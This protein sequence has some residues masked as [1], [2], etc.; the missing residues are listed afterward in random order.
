V[1][2]VTAWPPPARTVVWGHRACI[3]TGGP[4]GGPRGEVPCFVGRDVAQAQWEGAV[5]PAGARGAVPHEA[6]G[7]M[8]LVARVPALHPP[9]IVRE[10][11]GG[12]ERPAPAA[13]APA[14]L[15]GGG[16]NPRPA[17]AVARATGQVAKTA[18]VAARALAHFAAVR[19]PP[20]G[21]CRP[22]SPRS[23]ALAAGAA[24]NA[25]AGARR[26]R[27]AGRGPAAAARR[28]WRRLSPGST[29]GSPRWPRPARRG[30]APARW[31]GPTTTG[32][33]VRRGWAPCGPGPWGWPSPRWGPARG[34][35]ARPGWAWRRSSVPGELSVVGGP[36]GEAARLSVPCW[37]WG[38]SGLRA[39]PHASKPCRSG[40]SRRGRAKKWP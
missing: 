29:N 10:A 11:P 40:G 39:P 16:V 34:S 9:W 30:S 17:R 26:S 5:R 21:R 2:R 14:G 38:P 35:S 15:P 3:C 8:T 32:C 25:S 13:V 27:T 7:G 31:G 28:P 37:P 4:T 1:G 20:P 12:L 6:G 33:R 19:R 23:A 24:S 22:P 36:F 18:A